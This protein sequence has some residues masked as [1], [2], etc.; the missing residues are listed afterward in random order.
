VAQTCSRDPRGQGV[1]LVLMAA[2]SFDA[3]AAG[4]ARARG[5]Q[6]W[7]YNGALPRAGSLLLD[8]GVGAL[9]AS[10]WVAATH[11][12]GRWFLWEVAFWNDGNRGGRGPVDPFAEP[13][14]FHNGSGDAALLDGLLVYP[15]TQLAP[16]EAHSLGYAGVLPSIRL[17]SLRRGI[18][19]AGYLALA[20]A[21]HPAE[22]DAI[23][24]A[25]MPAA[26][27]EAALD[28]PVAWDRSGRGFSE[29]RTALRALIPRG[30]ALT[31]EQ[32]S[33]VLAEGARQRA[34]ARAA[35]PRLGARFAL[36]TAGLLAA[37]V[38]A[39]LLARRR[40]G[41]RRRATPPARPRDAR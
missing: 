41:A 26:L 25:A 40:P 31:T 23:A 20:R 16:F 29:A 15:G 5:K 28:G 18:Q 27:D 2:E 24:A 14:S 13:E 39:S 8:A 12:V 35:P 6:V 38:A 19:D 7:V 11:D 22:A 21:A 34:A 10:A 32:A 36:V 33:R 17:K 3:R 1:D 30:A 4:A 37:L 9:A